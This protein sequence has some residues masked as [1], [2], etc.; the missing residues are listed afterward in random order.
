MSAKKYEILI[1]GPVPA[2]LL[3]DA[4]EDFPNITAQSVLTGKVRDQAELQGLLR[5]LHE[6]GIEIVAFRQLLGAPKPAVPP[7]AEA[8]DR[9][10]VAS[11]FPTARAEHRS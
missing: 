1:T 2:A 9:A 6:L 3:A 8:S 7:D 5:R 4:L 10:L 11:D